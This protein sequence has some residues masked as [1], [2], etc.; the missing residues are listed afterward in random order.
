M[1]D[2]FNNKQ[3]VFHQCSNKL[4][5]PKKHAIFFPIIK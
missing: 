3:I 5:H 2:T 4:T 1:L